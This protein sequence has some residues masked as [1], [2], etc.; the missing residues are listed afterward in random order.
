[1]DELLLALL[2]AFIAGA[3]VVAFSLLSA[4]VGPKSFSGIFGAAPSIALAS[5]TIIVLHRG[6]A[7]GRTASFS[8]I[9]GAIAMAAYCA[10]A[11]VTVDRFGALRGSVYAVGAW[12]IVAFALYGLRQLVA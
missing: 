4:M 8:M 10:T 7:D 3:F 6:E 11:V 1:M 5:L 9:F 12:G 2:K